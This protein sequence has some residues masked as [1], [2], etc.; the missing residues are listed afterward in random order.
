MKRACIV[1]DWVNLVLVPIIAAMTM[2]GLVGL[3]DPALVT[4]AFIAYVAG[5]FVWVFLQPE[6]VPSLPTVI[7]AHHAVT[8]VLLCVPLK[9][10]HLHWYTCVDGLV[11][12]NTFF[13]IAR[14][15]FRSRTTRKVFS[16]LYWA[17][18][19][20]MRMVLY[21]L[22]VPLFWREMQMTEEAPWWEVLA[23][24]GSQTILCMFN[25]VLL[26]LSVMN[27]RKRRAAAGET[28]DG[29]SAGAAAGQRAAGKAPGAAAAGLKQRVRQ[30]GG[31]PD[32]GELVPAV[33]G[34]AAAALALK[35]RAV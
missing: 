30:R 5:D 10:P 20:S 18:F 17:S 35:A 32:E 16:W 13:L 1:H 14:R 26:A 24:V 8:C 12:L 2:A 22:M 29:A 7:L 4:Y 9:R 11:E 21:P 15:Q 3:I 27:W 33:K 31:S 19:L 28:K 6:A 25:V 34:A 23:C